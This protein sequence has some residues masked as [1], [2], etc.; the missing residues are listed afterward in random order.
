MAKPSGTGHMTRKE[1]LRTAGLT[2]AAV[3]GAASAT[4]EPDVISPPDTMPNPD[5]VPYDNH[6]DVY[7]TGDPASDLQNLQYAVSGYAQP[8]IH[9]MRKTRAG[10]A[11]DFSLPPAGV[12]EI[13]RDVEFAGNGSA[14]VGG[15][16]AFHSYG[17]CSLA[18][19]NLELR[20][21]SLAS[22]AGLFNDV[23]LVSSGSN[24][25]PVP[26]PAYGFIVRLSGALRVANSFARNTKV[27][28]FAQGM[29]SG[30]IV[31]SDFSGT[32]CPVF[33]DGNLTSLSGN[34]FSSPSSIAGVIVSGGSNILAGN[35]FSPFQAVNLLILPGASNTIANLGKGSVASGSNPVPVPEPKIVDYGQN[36]AINGRYLAV[37]PSDSLLAQVD[38]LYG[39]LSFLFSGGEGGPDVI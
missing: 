28:I 29:S 2:A 35:R 26:D 23:D 9:L 21:Q 30:H 37:G 38:E 33:L 17:G 14:I 34:S 6:L 5:I 19:K 39:G 18:L 10:A 32:A 4:G 13:T 24:P 8:S 16:I 36:S 3:A 12:V 1:F 15:Y 22:V 20:G 31:S 7:P 27:G 11:S 25:V